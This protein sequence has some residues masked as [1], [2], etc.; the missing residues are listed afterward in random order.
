MKTFKRES[1]YSLPECVHQTP[2]NGADEIFPFIK[3]PHRLRSSALLFSGSSLT[4]LTS[5]VTTYTVRT[6]TPGVRTHL[7]LTHLLSEHFR[8]HLFSGRDSESWRALEPL[9]L[10]PLFFFFNLQ[11]APCIEKKIIKKTTLCLEWNNLQVL[12]S[13]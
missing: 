2:G 6:V 5:T 11:R 3:Y 10:P 12:T 9:N 1:C 4:A 13:T 8:A 7:P